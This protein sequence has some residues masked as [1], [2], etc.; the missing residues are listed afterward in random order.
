MHEF[1]LID[2]ETQFQEVTQLVQGKTKEQILIWLKQ[3]G[4][5]QQIP[6]PY[7]AHLFGFC[8][9]SGRRVGFRLTVENTIVLLGDHTTHRSQVKDELQ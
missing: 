8:S 2:L 7:D 3:F 4:D 9:F 5:V 6:H 1:T